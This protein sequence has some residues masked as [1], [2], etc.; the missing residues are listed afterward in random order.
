[1]KSEKYYRAS[2]LDTLSR[3]EDNIKA[4]PL[5]PLFCC[6]AF[7]RGLPNGDFTSSNFSVESVAL[8]CNN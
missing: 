5:A 4:E 8:L 2:R 3:L 6:L 1:M 7:R